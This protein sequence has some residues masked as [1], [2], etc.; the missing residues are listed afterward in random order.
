MI[1]PFQD[2]DSFGEEFLQIVTVALENRAAEEQ[3]I[4]VIQAY[5][6]DLDW[7]E[8]GIHLEVG[9]GTGAV[10]RLMATRAQN[11]E[12]IGIDP[13]SGLIE[14]AKE[15]S[16]DFENIDFEIG[17]GGSL[18]FDDGSVNNIVMHTVLS[19]VPDPTELL[20]EAIRILK[21][22]GRIVVCDADFEKSSLGNFDG[23]PIKACSEYFVRNFVTHPYLI[24]EIRSL[25]SA[26]GFKV[27]KFRIDSRAITETDGG[28]AWIKM[29]TGQMVQKGQIATSLAE[30]LAEEYARRK[31][32]ETLYGFQ[33]FGTLVAIKAA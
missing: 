30:S 29:A 5:L 21:P 22:G 9:A 7:E 19:H 28:L 8:S 25:A 17:N 14:K 3:I 15:L 33:P 32:A 23:D 6:G 1:D 18:R 12:V 13:S 16:A 26:A 4:P 27:E 11:G 20:N 2:V 24:S 31:D 10:T